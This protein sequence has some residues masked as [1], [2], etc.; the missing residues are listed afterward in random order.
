[1]LNHR[2][3]LPYQIIHHIFNSCSKS[4]THTV[5]HVLLELH[6]GIRPVVAT[7]LQLFEA[8]TY[9]C[10]AKKRLVL[11]TRKRFEE[12]QRTYRNWLVTLLSELTEAVV[13]TNS[14]GDESQFTGY[15]TLSVVWECT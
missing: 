4:S 11:N 7:L 1:M 8:V 5:V 12:V 9:K 10:H 14:L 3:I 15:S 2:V 13:L 6:A